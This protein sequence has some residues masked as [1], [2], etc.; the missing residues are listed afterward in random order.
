LKA[1]ICLAWASK[2]RWR[3]GSLVIVALA[4]NFSLP[5]SIVVFGLALRLWYQAGWV[6]KPPFDAI[7]TIRSP[8]LV[9]TSGVVKG[10]PLLAPVVVSRSRGALTNGPLRT[11]PPLAR[12]SGISFWLNSCIAFSLNSGIGVS[13]CF[14]QIR[15]VSD[16]E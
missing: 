10:R 16:R 14:F 5:N 8:S 13:P 9:Y 11:L 1:G 4:W 12:N 7:I 6:G 2:R 15:P 3:S